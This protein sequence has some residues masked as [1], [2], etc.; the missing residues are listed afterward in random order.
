MDAAGRARA[1]DLATGVA[2]QRFADALGGPD[3]TG[4]PAVLMPVLQVYPDALSAPMPDGMVALPP[5]DPNEIL[6][7]AR[8]AVPVPTPA[9]ARMAAQR[10]A[11]DRVAQP[12][13]SGRAAAPPQRLR[14]AP[15]GRGEP[16][17][18]HALAPH[19]QAPR[20]PGSHQSP[21]PPVPISGSSAWSGRTMSP[22]EMA[23][24]F[25]QTF[26]GMTQ[27]VNPITQRYQPTAHAPTPPL[28]RNPQRRRNKGSGIWAVLLFLVIIAFASGIA[29]QLI[30]AVSELFNR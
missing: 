11:S 19:L 9:Q 10:A 4:D 24:F 28:P 13:R 27:G 16:D 23:G 25:R 1:P 20:Q 5:L 22:T 8:Q 29:Q 7:A 17:P 12:G 15:S 26:A 6:A 2:E 14:M 21:L 30:S 18:R 3:G